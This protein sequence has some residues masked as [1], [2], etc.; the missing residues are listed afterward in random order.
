VKQG[1]APVELLAGGGRTR[2]L[3]MHGAQAAGWRGMV[4]LRRLLAGGRSGE[5]KE[6]PQRQDGDDDLM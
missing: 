4:V 5:T 6:Q 2:R 3:E 1:D